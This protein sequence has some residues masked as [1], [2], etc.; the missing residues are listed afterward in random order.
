VDTQLAAYWLTLLQRALDRENEE[1]GWLH[2]ARAA[3]PYLLRQQQWEQALLAR[4][5]RT[6][7]LAI[8][9]ARPAE[10]ETRL[11]QL[12]ILVE[13]QQYVEASTVAGDLSDGVS[14]STACAATPHGTPLVGRRGASGHASVSS[15]RRQSG[16]AD[17]CRLPL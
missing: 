11:Q 6:Y 2:A 16:G 1:M 14:R 13:Q 17:G 9:T 15:S 7:A 5:G 4:A 3:T 10:A 8:T 12:S